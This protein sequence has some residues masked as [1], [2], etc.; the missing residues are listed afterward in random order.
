MSPKIVENHG[1]V[2]SKSLNK[3][4]KTHQS[5]DTRFYLKSQN[6]KMVGIPPCISCFFGARILGRVWRPAYSKK[7]L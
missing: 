3:Y 1:K 4:A 7:Q 5:M 2:T 6:K